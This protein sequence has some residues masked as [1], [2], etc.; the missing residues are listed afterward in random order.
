MANE[1]HASIC[2]VAQTRALGTDVGGPAW[3]SGPGARGR[4]GDGGR[5]IGRQ[6]A[7]PPLQLCSLHLTSPFAWGPRGEAG[8]NGLNGLTVSS[9]LQISPLSISLEPTPPRDC[10]LVSCGLVCAPCAAQR[11]VPLGGRPAWGQQRRRVPWS[12]GFPFGRKWGRAGQGD[13]AWGELA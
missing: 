4:G 1:G 2:P 6:A 7:L 9:P 13:E 5:A 3:D 12:S 11:A 8:T 10:S